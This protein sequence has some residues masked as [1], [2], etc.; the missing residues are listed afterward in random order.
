MEI[1]LGIAFWMIIFA[2]GGMIF[3]GM[4]KLQQRSLSQKDIYIKDVLSILKKEKRGE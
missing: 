2:C 1:L 3:I 4:S